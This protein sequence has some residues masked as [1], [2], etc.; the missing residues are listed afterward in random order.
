MN[1]LATACENHP[2]GKFV[3]TLSAGNTAAP[4]GYCIGGTRP[5]PYVLVSGHSTISDSV[6][7]RLLA[8]PTL[9]WMRG[10]LFLVQLD[11]LDEQLNSNPLKELEGLHFDKTFFLPFCAM[12]AFTQD[13]IEQGYRS[14]LRVCTQLGMIDGRGV[15]LRN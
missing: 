4:L 2:S 12:P 3:K 10:K 8:I 5:G 7:E 6:Y 9:S 14:V 1:L 11:T 13:A 15:S